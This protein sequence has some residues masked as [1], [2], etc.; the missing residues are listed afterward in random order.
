MLL[1]SRGTPIADAARIESALS[2][3]RARR[4]QGVVT[5]SV[6]EAPAALD[7]GP[8]NAVEALPAEWF[9]RQKGVVADARD[10]LATCLGR[11]GAGWHQELAR[12]SCAEL[13]CIL[14]EALAPV[15]PTMSLVVRWLILEGTWASRPS[16]LTFVELA[17][18]IS[19]LAAARPPVHLLVDASREPDGWLLGQLRPLEQFATAVSRDEL[20]VLA[21]PAQVEQVMLAPRS[22]AQALVRE[23]LISSR[24]DV[25]PA[26]NAALTPLDLGD[27]RSSEE[28]YLFERLEES[29]A[30]RGLFAL[31]TC[32]VE[33]AGELGR[34]EVDL[35]SRHLAIA[36]E[37]DGHFH[38]EDPEA[39]RRDRRKDVALQRAGFLVLRFLAS[40]VVSRLET[41]LS[42]VHAAVAARRLMREH[43]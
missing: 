6:V 17:T 26:R 30:T 4:R 13:T 1:V 16:Q 29:E 32:V 27:A 38:F 41:I 2:L 9:A 31:N 21:R 10:F 25:A 19:S 23:G 24:G 37:I 7:L 20:V 3:H 33:A 36:I 28:L 39:Y 22:R 35:L 14:D 43:R 18:A 42:T 12:K 15:A 11:G 5:L 34:C 8:P 40:D